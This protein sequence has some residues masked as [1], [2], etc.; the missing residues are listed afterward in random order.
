M[1]ELKPTDNRKEV[2]HTYLWVMFMTVVFLGLQIFLYYFPSLNRSK[3]ALALLQASPSTDLGELTSSDAVFYGAYLQSQADLKAQPLAFGLW[4]LVNYALLI[5][6]GVGAEKIFARQFTG[7][8][9][10]QDLTLEFKFL[11]VNWCY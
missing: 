7:K 4:M 9:Y 11:S 2:Y 8:S 1:A 6:I 10:Y 3:Q 5:L